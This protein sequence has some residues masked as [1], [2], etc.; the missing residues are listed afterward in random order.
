MS[1]MPVPIPPRP[2]RAQLERNVCTHIMP[3]SVCL[4]C[5]LPYRVD[6]AISILSQQKRRSYCC[7][8]YIPVGFLVIVVFVAWSEQFHFT[9]WPHFVGTEAKWRVER[10]RQILT[11]LFLVHFV[12]GL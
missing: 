1:F 7:Y 3:R 10:E 12:G 11:L 6:T 4:M 9:V 8:W 5:G 2:R